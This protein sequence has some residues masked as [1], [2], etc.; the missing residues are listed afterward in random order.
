MWIR[1]SRKDQLTGRRTPLPTQVV[2]NEEYFPM[3]Q[4]ENQKRVENLILEMADEYARKLGMSRRG[5]LQTTGGMA[6]AFLAMNEVFGDTFNVSQAE[7]LETA[8]FKE[9]WPKDQ[10]IIDIQTH[11]VKDSIVGP[12]MF[13]KMTGKLG[14]NPELAN[15]T[16]GDDDRHRGN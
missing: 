7:A 13:R 11:F 14:L 16:P 9:P 2:S 8:A 12:K 6:T 5:F 1:K 3:P 4:S 10:F 15:V